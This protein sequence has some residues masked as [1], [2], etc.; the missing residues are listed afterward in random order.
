MHL[1]CSK[2]TCT[3]Q[4]RTYS[5]LFYVRSTCV[6][7]VQVYLFRI[8][9]AHLQYLYTFMIETLVLVLVP[10]LCVLLARL[11][12]AKHLGSFCTSVPFVSE[13]LVYL[14]LFSCSK[15]F[16]LY[17]TLFVCF[18]LHLCHVR[19]L[20]F[21]HVHVYIFIFET[22][23][24]LY[25]FYVRNTP[26]CTLLVCFY[27]HHCYVRS[28]YL[29]V[30][31]ILPFYIRNICVLVPFLCSTNLCTSHTFLKQ[32][33]AGRDRGKQGALHSEGCPR[34]DGEVH[35][36][37]HLQDFH[38]PLHE[39][40]CTRGKATKATT[41]PLETGSCR[42]DGGAPACIPAWCVYSAEQGYCTLNAV[43]PSDIWH[44]ERQKITHRLFQRTPKSQISLQA[45]LK[46]KYMSPSEPRAP[47]LNW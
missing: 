32:Y 27:S 37:R 23:V 5:Y 2:H 43:R 1:S 26:A 25:L 28:A 33:H 22:L 16:C 10:F 44:L 3:H 29:L 21:I 35:K 38:R 7:F 8:R 39:G 14:Y 19:R 18:C 46:Y 11:L 4:T 9:H 12:C 13:T 45:N 41:K 42:D 34:S 20:A 40:H 31:Q 30:V 6:L 17:S 47:R 24:Y 36:P 15:H